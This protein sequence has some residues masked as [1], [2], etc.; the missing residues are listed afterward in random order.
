MFFRS[1][2]LL[3][4]NQWDPRLGGKK[5]REFLSSTSQRGRKTT[6]TI[7]SWLHTWNSCADAEVQE[8]STRSRLGCELSLRAGVGAGGGH[9]RKC[10]EA[11]SRLGAGGPPA[12]IKT[13]LQRC[14]LTL[15]GKMSMGNKVY[16][17]I[18]VLFTM[19]FEF[20]LHNSHLKLEWEAGYLLAVHQ[21]S[22][23]IWSFQ[24]SLAT[25]SSCPSGS[26]NDY[27]DV[28]PAKGLHENVGLMPVCR[29]PDITS[30]FLWKAGLPCQ[31]HRPSPNCGD[32][33]RNAPADLLLKQNKK[34]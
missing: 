3:E 10:A 19:C 12:G 4:A 20:I 2:A 25:G 7:V 26:V 16:T 22:K 21:N 6:N 11:D 9:G 34:K 27:S 18:Y 1:I 29:H 24:G 31:R 23:G 15:L 32:T 13:T 17:F 33:Y 8:D 5:E 14:G 30:R 28:S